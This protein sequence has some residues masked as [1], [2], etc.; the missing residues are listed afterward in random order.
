MK[1][2]NKMIRS[3]TYWV[4]IA[5]TGGFTTAWGYLGKRGLSPEMQTAYGLLMIMGAI[6]IVSAI[7]FTCV[8][9]SDR[10]G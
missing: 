1:I 10:S 7:I 8:T 3:P 9:R 2:I 5:A 4:V 6:F